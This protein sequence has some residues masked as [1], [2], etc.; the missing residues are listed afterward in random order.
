VSSCISDRLTLLLRAGVVGVGRVGLVPCVGTKLF[1][2]MQRFQ[3]LADQ[4]EGVDRFAGPFG[5]AFPA[6]SARFRGRRPPP[7]PKPP[8]TSYSDMTGAENT[9]SV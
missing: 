1:R 8:A 2:K 7:S 6:G 5:T 3:S 4:A 9:H